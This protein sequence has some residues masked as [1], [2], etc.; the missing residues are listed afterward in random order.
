MDRR[1]QPHLTGWSRKAS[2][3]GFHASED[4][5]EAEQPI[6]QQSG[7]KLSW[8]EET[9]QVPR[10]SGSNVFQEMQRGQRGW[11]EMSM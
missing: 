9:V 5:E 6:M 10:W 4:F 3:K 7:R 2:L 8:G 1:L 11:S